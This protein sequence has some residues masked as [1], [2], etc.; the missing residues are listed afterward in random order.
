MLFTQPEAKLAQMVVQH[1]HALLL[2]TGKHN[3]LSLAPMNPRALHQ[4]QDHGRML[5]AAEAQPSAGCRFNFESTRLA[6][7]F[8]GHFAE[9]GHWN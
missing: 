6:T 9:D 1:H 4:F 7:P 8:D 5:Y 3:S 2:L